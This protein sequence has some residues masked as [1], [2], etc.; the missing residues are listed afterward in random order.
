MVLA[1]SAECNNF[2]IP[3]MIKMLPKNNW[4]ITWVV[5]ENNIDAIFC[6]IFPLFVTGLK[7]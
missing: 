3:A 6:F 4:D 2:G 7:D 5:F 1:K